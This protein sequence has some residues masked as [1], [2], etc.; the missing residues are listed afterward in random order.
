MS[1]TR[2]IY[3]DAQKTSRSLVLPWAVL[4]Q[5][6][7]GLAWTSLSADGSLGAWRTS[8]SSGHVSVYGT[9]WKLST[10][11]S[12]E[13]TDDCIVCVNVSP[14]TQMFKTITF[15][16]IFKISLGLSYL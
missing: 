5:P 6:L 13:Q 10:Y 8:V 1:A 4:Q 11:L 16:C 12:N 15:L 14:Q 3:D 9:R 2:V 7:L